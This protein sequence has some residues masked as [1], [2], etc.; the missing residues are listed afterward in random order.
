MTSATSPPFVRR[1]TRQIVTATLVVAAVL[2]G[3]FLLYRFRIVVFLLLAAFVINV[4]ITP[5]VNWLV[6]RGRSRPL[7]VALVYLALLL[8]ALI[9]QEVVTCEKR[10]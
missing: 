3:F 6:A 4:A 9:N 2:G 8:V 1:D 10:P 5:A 7:A